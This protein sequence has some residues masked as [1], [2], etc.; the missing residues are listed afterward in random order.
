[1]INNPKNKLSPKK[2]N[3]SVN[4]IFK[5]RPSGVDFDRQSD[6]ISRTNTG[7]EIYR[8]GSNSKALK[9]KEGSMV[10]NSN[11]FDRETYLDVL[12]N[13]AED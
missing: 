6:A 8:F 3:I 5:E 12:Q 2:N 4:M 11:G 13:L 1:M 9:D 10:H 7:V